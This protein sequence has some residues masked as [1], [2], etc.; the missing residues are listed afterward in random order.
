M[1]LKFRKFHRKAPVLESVFD[2]CAG[3]LTLFFTEDLLWLAGSKLFGNDFVDF[4]HENTSFRILEALLWLHLIY[5]LT[6]IAFWF[7]MGTL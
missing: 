7:V 1:F 4:S 5:F 3:L 2:K 6:T